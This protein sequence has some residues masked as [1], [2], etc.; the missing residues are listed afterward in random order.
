MHN[1]KPYYLKKVAGAGQKSFY[2]YQ[3][4]GMKQWR[5]SPELGGKKNVF[6]ASQE[7]SLAVCPGDST[8]DGTWQAATGT[9]GRFKK[10][11]AVKVVCNRI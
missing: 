2:L 7:K 3:D 9:F 1:G 10:N 11:T 8:A 6:F 5:F 4:T